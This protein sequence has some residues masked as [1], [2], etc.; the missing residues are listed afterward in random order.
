SYLGQDLDLYG[1]CGGKKCRGTYC[2]DTLSNYKFFF[3]FENSNCKDYITEKFWSALLRRQVPVV[4]GGSSSLDYAKIAP[5]HSYIRVKDFKDVKSLV[6]YLRYLEQNET[7]YNEY[8]DWT[9]DHDVYSEVPARRKWWCNL[10]EALHNK[11]K[12]AQVYTDISG[13]MQD[14]QCPQ[15]SVSSSVSSFFIA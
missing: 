11:S 10:C 13:W 6:D 12:P 8:L 5:P 4:F 9:V 15:W 2:Y 7:A 14:D 1:K 3:T